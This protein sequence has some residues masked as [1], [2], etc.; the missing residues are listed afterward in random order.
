MLGDF[1]NQDK[2]AF[3]GHLEVGQNHLGP[4]FGNLLYGVVDGCRFVNKM[5]DGFKNAR[6]DFSLAGFVVH[7]K[8]IRHGLCLDR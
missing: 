1:F 8:N 6:Y 4:V 3:S 7:D 5:T 2:S